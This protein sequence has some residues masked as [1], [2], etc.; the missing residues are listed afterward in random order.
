MSPS[1]NKLGEGP[2]NAPQ[3]LSARSRLGGI[4]ARLE[5]LHEK[6]QSIKV[7]GWEPSQSGDQIP[8]APASGSFPGLLAQIDHVLDEAHNLA[9]YI[10]ARI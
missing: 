6:L 10:A 5:T 4:A 8:T 1:Y 7:S 9:D 3:E 2:A